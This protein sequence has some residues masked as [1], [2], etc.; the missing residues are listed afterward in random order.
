MEG[1]REMEFVRRKFSEYYA[2]NAVKLPEKAGQR[3]WGFGGWEGKIE[4]RPFAFGDAAGLRIYL[5]ANVPLYVS[6]SVAY[7]DRPDARPIDRKGWLGAELVFDLDA[8]HLNLPCTAR[9][10]KA[11]VCDE[12]LGEV[13]RQTLRLVEDYLVPD[14][15]IP[16]DDMEVNFSGNRGYH[17]HVTSEDMKRLGAYGRREILDYVSGTGLEFDKLFTKD[18]ARLVGPK[19]GDSGWAGRVARYALENDLSAVLP[20]SI[21]S[22]PERMGA[23]RRGVEKG[24]W[25][26]VR[27]PKKMDVWRAFVNQL[28]LRLGGEV[29]KQVTGDITKLIRAPDTLHGGTGLLA[30]RVAWKGL[31]RFDPLRDAAAFEKGRGEGIDVDVSQAPKIRFGNGEFGPFKQERAKL[32]ENVALYLICKKAARLS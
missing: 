18:G 10:G 29:D 17:V 22:R 8:D 28:G 9:H 23:F 3:E 5:A 27:I 14:F 16:R 7:Y 19:P 4:A 15:G 25:D 31:E 2:A 26:A 32:P 20:R 24:N 1:L 30:K 13:K 21:A 12:C 11:W 6:Y